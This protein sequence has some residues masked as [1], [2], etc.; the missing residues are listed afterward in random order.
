MTLANLARMILYKS[1][2][3]GVD[4]VKLIKGIEDLESK[5]KRLESE[6]LAMAS[7]K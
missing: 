7:D 4:D 2:A 1:H 3:P 5:V 6:I